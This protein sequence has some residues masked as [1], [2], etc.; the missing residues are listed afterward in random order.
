MSRVSPTE[1]QDGSE[2]VSRRYLYV[3]L[4]F[5]ALA[6]IPHLAAQIW[7]D[8][9]FTL[10]HYAAAGP[11]GIL[12][13]GYIA[14]NHILF[15]L[16]IYPWMVLFQETFGAPY[17][18]LRL[19]P[20][21]CGAVTICASFAAT[22]TLTHSSAAASLAAALVASSTVF[23]NFACQLR[24]YSQSYMLVALC[25]WLTARYYR[26]RTFSRL[27]PI[28][29]AGIGAVMT[30]PTNLLPVA[31]ILGWVLVDQVFIR[32]K[33][34]WHVPL[35]FLVPFPG[36]APYLIHYQDVLTQAGKRYGWSSLASPMAHLFG[37]NA[38]SWAPVL[39]VAVYLTAT[40]RRRSDTQE[41]GTP[42]VLWPLALTSLTFP[43][44]GALPF[45]VCP[46][47]R[48]LATQLPIWAVLLACWAENGLARP[49]PTPS[50]SDLAVIV[51]GQLLFG[52]L[53]QLWCIEQL[54]RPALLAQKPQNLLLQYYA[55]PLFRPRQT[56]QAIQSVSRTG[57]R[58]FIVTDGSDPYSLGL[59][60]H[61]E[62]VKG[63]AFMDA[64]R[65]TLMKR[66]KLFG[67][68]HVPERLL[69][70]TR[71]RAALAKMLGEL[72]IDTTG[73]E[74]VE[75]QDC[76]FFKLYGLEHAGGKR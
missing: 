48:V 60:C 57:N 16:C 59:Y 33:L 10:V 13:G 66:P 15:S 36:L 12:T 53:L 27:W 70:I 58:P 39:V 25:L 2:A 23:L 55:S 69:L 4:C 40:T 29:L 5:F 1:K 38:L 8:E 14:N 73:Y 74:P 71:S 56:A 3:A 54:C 52:A 17:W 67:S 30:I 20:F 6:S 11:R 47:P 19:L 7:Y 37:T 76:G 49:R 65:G 72:Q 28:Y 50:R 31:A 21:L 63:L 42:P 75:L 44:L 32:R 34:T 62:G 22:R 45:A 51:A 68:G 61:A 41:Q 24:G 64:F 43:I 9:A 46:Y 18:T 35:L 26:R